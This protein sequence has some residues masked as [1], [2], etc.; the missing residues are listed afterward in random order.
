MNY[1]RRI[2]SA[3]FASVMAVMCGLV[4]MS[5]PR[6]SFAQQAR[7]NR[8]QRWEYCAILNARIKWPLQSKEKYTGIATICYFRNSGCRSEEVI[9]ELTYADFL[10]QADAKQGENYNRNYTAPAKATESALSKAITKLGDD[11]WEMIGDGRIDF[12][13]GADNNVRAIYFKRRT[14]H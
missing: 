10:K 14:S 13:S 12:A 3:G 6:Q 4:V 1:N 9:F 5:F 7:R 8:V 2:V 11:G